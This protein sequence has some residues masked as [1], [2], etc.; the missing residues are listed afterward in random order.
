MSDFVD[1]LRSAACRGCECDEC[2]LMRASAAEIERLREQ[3]AVEQAKHALTIQQ[4]NH[5]S[6][7]LAKAKAMAQFV[8]WAMREGPWDG[9]DLDGG[10]VQDMGAKLGLLQETIYDPEKHG[11]DEWCEPGDSYYVLDPTVLA[12]TDDQRSEK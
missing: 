7:Q 12:L 3:L 11:E 4:S 10:A 6:Q 5:F 8:R 1:K 2:L 9:G